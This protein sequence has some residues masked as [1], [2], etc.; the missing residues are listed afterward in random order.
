M[1]VISAGALASLSQC[2][3][4]NPIENATDSCTCINFTTWSD[5]VLNP[6]PDD[7]SCQ[8]PQVATVIIALICLMCVFPLVFLLQ[9]DGCH[10][11]NCH[12]H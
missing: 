9:C 6:D 4:F 1:I 5:A 10:D 7:V 8:F 12:L 11:W 3:Q 2:Q